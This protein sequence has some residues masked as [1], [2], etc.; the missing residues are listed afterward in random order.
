[1]QWKEWLIKKRSSQE[2]GWGLSLAVWLLSSAYIM[3]TVYA[4]QP[5]PLWEALAYTK[6]EALLGWLN[7][8][9]PLLAVGVVWFITD[10][11]FYSAGAVCF[12][13]QMFS[14]INTMKIAYRDDP[15]VPNDIALY[16]EAISAAGGYSL[17]MDWA[18]IGLIIGSLLFFLACGR[19]CLGQSGRYPL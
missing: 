18:A 9:P 16:R 11:L 19:I 8:V 7:F 12:V 10:R 13:F 3:A 1:M 17:D 5:G 14:F 15:L 4:I 6:N 2:V